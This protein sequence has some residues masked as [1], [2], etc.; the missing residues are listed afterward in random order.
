MSITVCS[1]SILFTQDIERI[2][3]CTAKGGH[4][5][6]TL[7]WSLQ[8]CLEYLDIPD[9]G[10]LVLAS[11]PSFTPSTEESQAVGSEAIEKAQQ[12]RDGVVTLGKMSD[13]IL[14]NVGVPIWIS[15]QEVCSPGKDMDSL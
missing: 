9:N 15:Q 10:T 14:F 7:S 13:T 12:S 3:T 11:Q 5:L 4:T 6:P 2:P 8:E 1:A